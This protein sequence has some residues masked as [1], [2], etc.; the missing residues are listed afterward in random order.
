MTT[1]RHFSHT[2]V[3]RSLIGSPPISIIICSPSLGGLLVH[4]LITDRFSALS[5]V[6]YACG[7]WVDRLQKAI[8]GGLGQLL[9]LDQLHHQML[10]GVPAFR[11]LVEAGV[12]DVT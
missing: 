9:K 4:P 5:T 6:V 10:A 3:D 8:G 12:G 2:S 7:G 1:T 11:G